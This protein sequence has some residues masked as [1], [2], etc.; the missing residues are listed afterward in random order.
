MCKYKFNIMNILPNEIILHI[1]SYAQHIKVS[2]V[3]RDWF[4]ISSD[5]KY[6]L[7][8][9][10]YCTKRTKN[11]VIWNFY[12]SVANYTIFRIYKNGI[13]KSMTRQTPAGIWKRM[14]WY[15]DGKAKYVEER[16]FFN[17]PH[18]FKNKLAKLRRWHPN[19]EFAELRTV[20]TRTLWDTNGKLI[21][22][23]IRRRNRYLRGKHFE[24]DDIKV[25]DVNDSYKKI[26]HK[27]YTQLGKRIQHRYL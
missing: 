4:N 1:L 27:L 11:E 2:E 18:G 6:D 24:W 25:K 26:T 22:N 23:Y 12:P 8:P 13:I 10:G 15:S 16:K 21:E 19:G 3:C 5:V 14:G 17:T 9:E 20:T 7:L